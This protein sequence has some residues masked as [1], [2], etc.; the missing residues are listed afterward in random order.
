MLA[1]GMIEEADI[2][3][4]RFQAQKDMLS[5][6]VTAML[7]FVDKTTLK[8]YEVKIIEDDDGVKNNVA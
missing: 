3:T 2:P 6:E 5:G 8:K 1:V 4:F 7:Q